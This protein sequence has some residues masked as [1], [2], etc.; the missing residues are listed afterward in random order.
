M[1]NKQKVTVQA[2][3]GIVGLGK[4]KRL[5]AMRQ[6][7]QQKAEKLVV[8]DKQKFNINKKEAQVEQARVF[9]KQCMLEI[10]ASYPQ[11]MQNKLFALRYGNE[12][13][14]NQMSLRQLF[15]LFNIQQSLAQE[16][17]EFKFKE[18]DA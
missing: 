8:K 3:Q 18:S 10:K 16:L 9:I 5:A 4:S 6:S 1:E 7:T 2:T 13:K 15:G 12:E 11:G 17:A 14:I